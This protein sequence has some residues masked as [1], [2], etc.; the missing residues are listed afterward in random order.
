MTITK[1]VKTK[2]QP[3]PPFA[4]STRKWVPPLPTSDFNPANISFIF[5]LNIELS[6]LVNIYFYCSIVSILSTLK[7]VFSIYEI[8]TIYT[9]AS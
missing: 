5:H 2:E 3:E 6:M 1:S 4:L 7:G 8:S 9:N